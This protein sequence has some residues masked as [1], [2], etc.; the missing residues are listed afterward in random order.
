MP[1]SSGEYR[2]ETYGDRIAEE[3][4]DFYGDV[5]QTDET[6]AFLAELAG[7]GPVLELGIGTG[8]VALPLADKGIEVHGIDASQRM[9][10]QMRAKPGGDKIPV[11]IGDMADLDA[12]RDMYSLVYVV[13]NTFYA[14]LTQEDQVKCFARVAEHLVPGGRFVLRGFVPDLERYSRRQN[15][16]VEKI[17]ADEI[18]TGFAQLDPVTQTIKSQTVVIKNGQTMTYPAF[19]RYCWPGELN[20]MAQLAGLDLEDRWSDWTR[21]EFTSN[22]DMLI[23]VYRKPI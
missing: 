14:M 5:L 1:R 11:N 19:L 7:D 2:P 20:L 4:D 10:D 18:R 13:F 3:Y 21:T 16:Q 12:P 8:R 17:D 15:T 6:V 23:S 9:I 22:S